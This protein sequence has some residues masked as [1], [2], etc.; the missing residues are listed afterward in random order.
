MLA[1]AFVAMVNG[2]DTAMKADPH[3]HDYESMDH[4]EHEHHEHGHGHGH[5]H[6]HDVVDFNRVFI[7]GISLNVVIVLLEAGAG[8][9]SHSMSL[10]AD[11]GHN[12]SDVLGLGLAWAAHLLS[13]RAPTPRYTYGLRATSI[14]AALFNA[15]FLLVVT[16][17]LMFAAFQRLLQPEPVGGIVMIIVAVI[18]IIVNGLTALMLASRRK[19]DLNIRGAFLHM[20]ADAAISAGVVATGLLILLTGWLRLDPLVSLAIN[21]IIIIGTWDLLRESFK[22]SLGAAPSSVKVHDVSNYLKSLPQVAALHDLHIWAMST[23]ETALTAHLVMPEGHPGDDFLMSI[24]R[25][26]RQTYSIGHATIQ[27]ETDVNTSCALA[28]DDAV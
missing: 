2:Y 5:H 19:Q 20:V 13:Q 4:H 17:A 8:L 24:C 18:G 9:W 21:I 15:M 27:V 10:L 28:P 16:G 26:L 12:L 11:A 6:H 22:L 3:D 7:I 1:G 23:S 25:D 14:L